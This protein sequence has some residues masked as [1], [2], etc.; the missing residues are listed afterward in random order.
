[1]NKQAIAIDVVLAQ[2]NMSLK[3]DRHKEILLETKD[4][5]TSLYSIEK[6]ANVLPLENSESLLT[7]IR[8]FKNRLETVKRLVRK[9]SLF[10]KDK[11]L[12]AA[13]KQ[14]NIS[15]TALHDFL[16]T[17]YSG[18]LTTTEKGKAVLPDTISLTQNS[19]KSS[20]GQLDSP[21]NETDPQ[22]LNSI[23]K[24]QNDI[25]RFIDSL[26]W[27]LKK[28]QSSKVAICAKDIA[29][30]ASKIEDLTLLLKDEQKGNIKMLA[31]GLKQYADKLHETAHKGKATHKQQ[32]EITDLIENRFGTLSIG[33]GIL[34]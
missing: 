14:L 3:K 29:N 8:E 19:V 18:I 24:A 32:H 28:E 25:A 2:M 7:I 6:E 26:H 17:T 20:P 1:M 15:Q 30:L 5:E 9:G 33:I 21:S 4:I 10:D 22:V 16:R 13:C 11:P 12:D 31:S 27:A 23:R 34:K